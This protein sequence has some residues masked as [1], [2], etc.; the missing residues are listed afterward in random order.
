M[1]T[2]IVLGNQ[3]RNEDQ[4]NQDVRV[5]HYPSIVG[6][7]V[8]GNHVL[9]NVYYCSAELEDRVRYYSCHPEVIP[10]PVAE[11]S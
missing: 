1:S 7:I 8:V 11:D 9:V 10:K 4:R 3:Q 2:C 6:V 5:E